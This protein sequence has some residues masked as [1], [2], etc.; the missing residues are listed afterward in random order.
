MYS[1]TFQQ[2]EA[3][4]TAAKYLNLS[5]AADAMFIS[6]SALSK[7]LQRFEEGRGASAVYQEQPGVWR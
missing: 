2:M 7:T 1:I 4:L 3:F 5:K 6:Q